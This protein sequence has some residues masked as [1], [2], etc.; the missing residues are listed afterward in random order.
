MRTLEERTTVKELHSQGK[1]NSEIS[2]IT[3]ISRR[4]VSDI[5]NDRFTKMTGKIGEPFNPIKF[6]EEQQKAYSYILG[7]YLGD[8]HI[9]LTKKNVYRLMI[10][11]DIKYPNIIQEVKD[12]LSIILP[13][14]STSLAFR[15]SNGIINCVN[16]KVYSK[17]LKDIFPQHGEGPKHLRPIKLE[18]WQQD[19]VNKFPKDFL[20]G[21]IHSDGSRYVAKQGKYEQIRYC[22][23]NASTDI[24][25]L[26]CAALE[27]IGITYSLSKKAIR[28]KMKHHSY[29]VF[30]QRKTYVEFLESFIGPKS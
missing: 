5:V 23:T 9:V 6:T 10:T 20:R 15:K 27:R 28:D 22:F 11:S 14:N 13:N 30:V 24:I 7:Q 3:G 25:A 12:K 26:Y 4:T 29:N 17:Q 18:S 19:I 2:R 8:G 1:N 16:V 21:L